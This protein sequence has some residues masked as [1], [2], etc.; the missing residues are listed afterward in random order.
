[1][2]LSRKELE[3]QSLYNAFREAKAKGILKEREHYVY[4]I[5]IAH[6]G[7]KR[8]QLFVTEAG[9]IALSKHITA[10]PKRG[11]HLQ[12]KKNPI[13]EKALKT[14]TEKK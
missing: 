14:R 1:M 9:M 5:A 11:T 7:R 8:E 6:D 3:E 4:E 2:K 12:G 13:R 10:R